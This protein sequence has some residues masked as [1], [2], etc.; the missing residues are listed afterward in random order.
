M[1]FRS[2]ATLNQLCD[3]GNGTCSGPL[4]PHLKG[5]H[6]EAGSFLGSNKMLRHRFS[7][8]DYIHKYSYSTDYFKN[9]T[10]LNTLVLVF[11]VLELCM[12]LFNPSSIYLSIILQYSILQQFSSC[13][14]SKSMSSKI[15]LLFKNIYSSHSPNSF[16]FIYPCQSVF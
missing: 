3:A 6:D 14:T 1:N 10:Y 11:L 2:S 7:M 4:F 13:P 12:Q 5:K 8:G 15:L 9:T 16:L